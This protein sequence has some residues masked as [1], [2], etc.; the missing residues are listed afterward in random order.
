MRCTQLFLEFPFKKDIC[1]W[2]HKYIKVHC[3]YLFRCFINKTI[4]RPNSYPRLTL[5]TI[6]NLIPSN[7]SMPTIRVPSMQMPNINISFP[8]RR[9]STQA[10][11]R[12]FGFARFSNERVSTVNIERSA[13]ETPA[14]ATVERGELVDDAIQRIDSASFLEEKVTQVSPD[15]GFTNVTYDLVGVHEGTNEPVQSGMMELV[16]ASGSGSLGA[17]DVEASPPPPKPIRIG[18]GI[19]ELRELSGVSALVEPVYSEVVDVRLN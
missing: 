11:G 2:T 9:G 4:F 12:T 19:L 10:G 1:I 14:D 18:T 13:A 8:G 16:G 6:S 3:L 7:L 17:F 5:P 15:S